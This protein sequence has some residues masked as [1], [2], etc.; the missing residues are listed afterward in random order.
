MEALK[1][2]QVHGHLL[3]ELAGVA[4]LELADTPLLPFQARLH[5]REL[6]PQELGGAF[7][8]QLAHLHIPI[9]VEAG[10]GVRHLGYRLGIRSAV[11]HCEGD[12]GAPCP[13]PRRIGGSHLD[14]YVTPQ[15][16]DGC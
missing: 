15:L 12:R 1:R 13:P 14:L 5:L 6:G 16:I 7:G 8:P 11:A 4:P 9:D 10:Q 3:R 2:R